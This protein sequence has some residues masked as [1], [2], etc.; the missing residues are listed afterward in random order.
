MTLA[1]SS[2]SRQSQTRPDEQLSAS[3]WAS[4]RLRAADHPHQD[5][6][7]RGEEMEATCRPSFSQTGVA[8]NCLTLASYTDSAGDL[9]N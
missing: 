1:K 4:S 3:I 7:K 5:E 8:G 9:E 6:K 2:E